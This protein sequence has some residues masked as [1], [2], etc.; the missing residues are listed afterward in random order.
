MTI[1]RL[2]LQGLAGAL[3]LIGAALTIGGARLVSLGGSWYYLLSGLATVVSAGL[4]WRGRRVGFWIYLATFGA[5]VIWALAEVGLAFWLLAPRLGL[6]LVLALLVLLA[7]RRRVEPGAGRPPRRSLVRAATV[8]V[9]LAAA[10]GIAFF[11]TGGT[12]TERQAAAS[13]PVRAAGDDWRAY[14]RTAAGTRYAPATEITPQN[15]HRLEVAW[16]Y[17]TGDLPQAYPGNRAG[18]MFEATPLKVGE[19]LYFCSPHNLVIALD[20]DTGKERWRYDPRIDTTGVYTLACRGVASYEAHTTV[21]DCPRRIL[22]A[23]LDGRLIAL[24]ADTGA[25]C[26]D[27]GQDGEVSLHAG[28]GPITPG[29]YLVT[30]P[31]TIVGDVA[32]VGGFVLDNMSTDEPSGVVRGY[33]VLT[34]RQ[35]WAW[36]AGRPAE[37]GP[38]RAGDAYTRGSPNAWSVFSA[39]EAL[40]LVYVPTGNAPP[41]YYGGKRTAAMDRY[42]SSVVALEAATGTLRWA[43]QTVHHD[44]WDYDVASQPVLVDLPTGGGTVPALI[45]PTKQ[46]E[47]FLLD[48]RSGRPLA[49]VEEQAV[50]PGHVPGERYA[51]TQPASVGMPSFMPAPLRE[52]DMWGTTPLDQLWCR[53]AFRKLRYE[54]KFTPPGLDASLSWPGNNGIMNWGSVSVD[55]VRQL[56]VVNSTYMPLLLQLIERAAAPP[57]ERIA[58]EG[59]AAISPQTGTPYAVRTTRPFL[60]PLGVP[61]NAPPWGRLSVVDLKARKLLWQR[62]L[63][64][65]RDHAPFGIAVPGAFAQGGSVVTGGGLIFV[66]AALDNEL[67]AFDLAS[68]RELWKGRLPAGGQATPMSYVSAKSGRQYVVIAAGGHQYMHTTI[69]DYVIAYRLAD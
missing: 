2:G 67:R 44:L 7:M 25:R 40:G 48:R 11:F 18:Y 1:R 9:L 31:P 42:S 68:G 27:F 6:P 26:P 5:T 4:I 21:T 49:A 61:C 29:Y 39:D 57:G 54:G 55:E 37:A 69:G 58:V 47:V 43:F 63:G 59:D 36:D 32:V 20:A 24:D 28:L 15:V 65:S 3:L 51:P 22:T 30:S 16:T 34:G 19:T 53:I 50:P 52:A 62:P 45:Q 35:L 10:A 56:M 66:A 64:T 23:T 60:S 46:G 41:D 13:P 17:R 38:W 33:D 12:R 14:G 8:V